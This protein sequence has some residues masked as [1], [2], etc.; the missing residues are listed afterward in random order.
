MRPPESCLR[1]LGEQVRQPAAARCA[2]GS[3][4][5]RPASGHSGPVEEILTRRLDPGLPSEVAAWLDQ[6][7]SE[8]Q[9]ARA[10]A[11]R[12]VSNLE[13]LAA[14]AESLAAGINMRFLYDEER[15]MFGIG[16][17]VGGPVEFTSHYDLLAS[18]CRIASLV[19]IAKGD[20]PVEHWY[21]LGRPLRAF[22]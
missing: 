20:V 10:N 17:A 18:E 4:A 1:P 8:Y 19:A 9:E 5:P 6:L 12:A 21:T 14:S 7:D 15:R 2:H 13:Q 11:A 22:A 16:Y 3:L